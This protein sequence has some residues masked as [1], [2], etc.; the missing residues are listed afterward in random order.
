MDRTVKALL[1]FIALGLWANVLTAWLPPVSAAETQEE[2]TARDIRR[3]VSRY[4]TVTGEV[5]L[6]SDD[7]GSLDGGSIDC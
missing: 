6:Y 4:C 3:L 1:L 5:W 7:Y 2:W